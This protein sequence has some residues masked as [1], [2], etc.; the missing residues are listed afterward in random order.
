MQK[1][2]TKKAQKP[3]RTLL[4]FTIYAIVVTIAL[5]GRAFARALD[6]MPAP[7]PPNYDVFRK[8]SADPMEGVEIIEVGN[9]AVKAPQALKDAITIA[10]L[11]RYKGAQAS[12]CYLT[13]LAVSKLESGWRMNA[14]GDHGQSFGP[15]QLYTRV[16]THITKEQ[17][18]NPHFA[19]EWTLTRMEKYGYPE[20]RAWSVGSHNSLTPSVNAAYYKKVLAIYEDLKRQGI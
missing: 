20:K 13:L 2:Y 4:A 8:V 3:F 1:R 19:A 9:D 18:E 10:C 16:H 5:T 14:V 6:Q 12:D 17:A 11:R 7:M 15:F